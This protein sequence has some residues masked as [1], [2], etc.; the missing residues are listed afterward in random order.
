MERA[1]NNKAVGT[2]GHRRVD[3]EP[4]AAAIVVGSQHGNGSHKARREALIALPAPSPDLDEL[5]DACRRGSPERRRVALGALA[6][7][8]ARPVAQVLLALGAPPQ[9]IPDLVNE[10]LGIV[11]PERVLP[12]I[13]GQRG[14]FNGLL[15]R[16][17]RRYLADARR[18]HRRRAAHH[19]GYR[20]EIKAI[21][22]TRTRST[23]SRQRGDDEDQD[24]DALHRALR[25]TRTYCLANNMLPHWR[26]F[27]MSHLMPLGPAARRP[28]LT[29]I[30]E[31]LNAFDRLPGSAPR[32][33][34]GPAR[35]TSGVDPCISPQRTAVMIRS[36]RARLRL[37][38]Q[39]IADNTAAAARR[40]VRVCSS[41]V[42]PFFVLIGGG[43]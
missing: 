23:R 35:S 32:S 30:S 12:A 33:T 25:N 4:A 20:V 41:L 27:A 7:L 42:T 8:Y 1:G 13:D 15:M 3:A 14:S 5:I 31:S 16:V 34:P 39:S 19:E 36:V 6:V 40:T 38:L 10:F 18:D 11:V 24:V 43:I 28:S 26:A 2:N 9:D 17:L 29:E 37:E 21:I 22:I